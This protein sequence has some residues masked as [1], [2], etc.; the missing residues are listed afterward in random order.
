[1]GK[2]NLNL[3]NINQLEQAGY[4]YRKEHKEEMLKYSYKYYKDK[5]IQFPWAKTYWNIIARCNYKSHSR[6]SYYGGRGIKCLITKEELKR[7][8]FRDKAYE[9][10]KPSIDREDPDENYTLKNCRYMEISKNIARKRSK[11]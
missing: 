5:W 3:N 9:M 11:I 6:Y 10:N 8:W 7:L 2:W 1:M 4:K